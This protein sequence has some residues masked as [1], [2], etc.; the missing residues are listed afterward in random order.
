MWP[1][2]TWLHTLVVTFV[3]FSPASS[4]VYPP[5]ASSRD[6]KMITFQASQQRHQPERILVRLYDAIGILILLILPSL[7]FP[8]LVD[9]PCTPNVSFLH[10][11][12]PLPFLPSCTIYK[13]AGFDCNSFSRTHCLCLRS[14]GSFQFRHLY[15]FTSI[16]LKRWFRA[17]N[18][19]MQAGVGMRKAADLA[20]WQRPCI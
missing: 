19:Q 13:S 15:A 8:R 5:S 4:I 16:E 1:K 6:A 12:H 3:I 9:A 17:V 11:A 18:L 10:L 14:I 7:L 2:N 20:C